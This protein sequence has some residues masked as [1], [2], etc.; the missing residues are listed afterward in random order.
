MGL[1][2]KNIREY[3]D[4]Q[5][6]PYGPDSEAYLVDEVS[7]SDSNPGK[8]FESPHGWF[9]WLGKQSYTHI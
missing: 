4:L 5:G 7:G 9:Y 2:P 1:Y 6:I 3:L 8:T